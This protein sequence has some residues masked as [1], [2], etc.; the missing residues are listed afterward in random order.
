M[1]ILKEIFGSRN[2]LV[3][4]DNSIQPFKE[5]VNIKLLNKVLDARN[6]KDK[7]EGINPEK[8]KALWNDYQH[9]LFAQ[10]YRETVNGFSPAGKALFFCYT[11]DN[12]R[13]YKEA[14]DKESGH[15]LLTANYHAGKNDIER[16]QLLKKYSLP[17][18]LKKKGKPLEALFSTSAFGMGMDIPNILYVA[19]LDLPFT[20]EDFVQE[21]GRAVR[22][23]KHAK[24]V[25]GDDGKVIALVVYDDND[26]KR[27]DSPDEQTPGYD[28]W[29]YDI[30][31]YWQKAHETYDSIFDPKRHTTKWSIK[32]ESWKT[33]V[34][35]ILN[36]L[37][38]NGGPIKSGYIIRDTLVFR[39]ND[40]D[41]KKYGGK[42]R[43]LIEY[44]I[45]IKD[46]N[47]YC[48]TK[49]SDLLSKTHLS[50]DNRFELQDTIRKGIRIGAITKT[51]QYIN[52][53]HRFSKRTKKAKVREQELE[54]VI[55]SINHTF[56][57][58][59]GKS[60][61]KDSPVQYLEKHPWKI[62]CVERI[63]KRY[64]DIYEVCK[65]IAEYA[66]KNDGCY[67]YKLLP[68][69]N[70]STPKLVAVLL[71]LVISLNVS[72]SNPP[73]DLI[74]INNAKNVP[75]SEI[76]PPKWEKYTGCLKKRSKTMLNLIDNHVNDPDDTRIKKEIEDY[77][78]G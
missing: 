37:S 34:Q 24:D 31:K 38:C 46:N 76:M 65:I 14:F 60:I 43:L 33:D 75:L 19:H 18:P 2:I 50:F 40:D 9:S 49:Y 45:S 53:C 26:R 21:I 69:T 51:S 7:K 11:R 62:G 17:A 25:L 30:N 78:L 41:S 57:K 23:V 36:L 74:L 39:L 54:V 59:S 44:L 55:K 77:L 35:S 22:D 27:L 58:A 56:D 52:I 63:K 66:Y 3:T 12:T 15:S 10:R 32:Y 16:D 72:L 70:N 6:E 4:G 5:I 8:V 64:P 48:D 1:L 42:L 67:V 47:S 71:I 20:I 61:P 28:R 68:F 13:D 73:A 29:K